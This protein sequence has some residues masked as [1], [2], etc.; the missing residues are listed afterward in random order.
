MRKFFYKIIFLSLILLFTNKLSYSQEI[1]T[2]PLYINHL[3]NIP[4][5]DQILFCNEKVPLDFEDVRERLDYELVNII[6]S[7]VTTTMWF[8]RANKYFG[9]IDK[10]LQSYNLPFDFKYVALIESNLK[11]DAKSSAGASGPWQFMEATGKSYG[12]CK[13]PY[14]D[15]RLHWDESTKAALRHLSDLVNDFGSCFLALAAYNAGSGRVRNAMKEQLENSF[16]ALNLPRETER[17]VLR[18]I[19]AKLIME[20]PK[21]YG[22]YLNNANLYEPELFQEIS[23]ELTDKFTPVLS[24][25]KK[26]GISYRY[27]FEINPHI[28]SEKLPSGKYIIKIPYKEKSLQENNP[29]S[30]SNSTYFFNR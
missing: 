30:S 17:Y 15:E 24:L 12:L 4:V 8:K 25:A 18:A 29:A 9:E 23:I 19:A 6:G 10:Y 7:P 2:N 13:N 14:I 1:L 28:T 5:P 21:K 16:F 26:Y 20:N 11:C 27:F 22:I 3:L